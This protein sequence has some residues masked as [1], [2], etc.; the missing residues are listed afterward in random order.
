M[1]IREEDIPAIK[2]FNKVIL[3]S[4]VAYMVIFTFASILMI[5]GSTF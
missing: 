1:D 5:A 4:I 3:A 2:Y